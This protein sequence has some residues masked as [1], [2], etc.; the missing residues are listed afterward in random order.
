MTEREYKEEFS[1]CF[2]SIMS[3]EAKGNAQRA[4]NRNRDTNNGN[5][6]KA[7]EK[8]RFCKGHESRGASRVCLQRKEIL[9]KH[10]KE[11][12][13]KQKGKDVLNG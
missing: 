12:K 1:L 7:G 13:I 2:K 8:S 6:L 10:L 5:L 3:E 9:Q 11:V 4:Y